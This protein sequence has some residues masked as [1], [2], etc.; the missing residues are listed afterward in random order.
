MMMAQLLTNSTTTANLFMR[1]RFFEIDHML[2]CLDH[3]ASRIVNANHHVMC[4][5]ALPN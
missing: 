2:V 5:I 4:F 3:V 1:S